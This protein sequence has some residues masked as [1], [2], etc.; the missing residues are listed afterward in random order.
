MAFLRKSI[1]LL[2]GALAAVGCEPNPT[3]GA[4]V[5]TIEG[6]PAGV[7]VAARVTGPD[8]FATT[9]PATGTIEGLIPGE[10]RV[11]VQS[12]T[13]GGD[14]Y[15]SSV[16]Q[17]MLN[18]AAG[19][20][21]SSTIPYALTSGSM[22]FTIGG[23][24]TGASANVI[25][26]RS[27]GFARLVPASGVQRG[28]GAGSYTIHADTTV[29]AEGDKFGPSAPQQTVTIAAS[30]TPVPVSVAFSQTTGTIALSI[31]GLPSTVPF[32]PVTV[33][34]PQG[35]FRSTKVSTSFHGLAPGTYTISAANAAGDC[36][37]MYVANAAQQ[38][39]EV[40]AVG[41]TMGSVSY[42]NGAANP[43]DLNL[44]IVSSQVIQV[45]Q[46]SAGNV[47]IVANRPALLRIYGIANQCNEVVPG[48]RVTFS[49]GTVVNVPAPEASVRTLLSEGTL[50]ATWNVDIP[51]TEV[52]AGLSFNAV[53]D[54]TNAFAEA[55]ES[56][57]RY[58]ASG[59][60]AVNVVALAPVKLVM[61]PVSQTTHGTGAISQANID[62]FL[63]F[64]RRVHPVATYDVVLGPTFSTQ[65]NLSSG[66]DVNGWA[67]I[68]NQLDAARVADAGANGVNRFHHG[69]VA[70]PFTGLVIAG[71]AYV[72]GWSGLTWDRLPSASEI[73]AHEFGHNYNQLHAPCPLSIEPGGPNSPDP[74]YPYYRAQIGKFGY[75]QATQTLRSPTAYTDVMGYCG[76]QWISDYMYKR[77]LA[78]L[79]A[80]QS[81]A[82]AVAAKTTERVLLVWGRIINGA[83]VLEPAFEIDGRAQLPGPGPHR[84]AALTPDGSE[85]FNIS[86]AGNDIADLPGDNESFAFTVPVSALGGQQVESLLLT[87]RGR[88]VRN[89]ISVEIAAG[90]TSDP[91]LRMDR[92]GARE[93]RLRWNAARYPVVMVRDPASGQVLSFA[94]GGDATLVI[95]SNELELHYSN[96]VRS[97]R[98]RQAIP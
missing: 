44:R 69:I 24:P 2:I 87:A 18:V 62:Q 17:Q 7:P 60:K 94:R 66:N 65:T 97:V 43:A 46:D 9:V 75:D 33:S 95:D 52:Q 20:T 29:T 35:Y 49:N 36:P 15:T 88:T 28:L 51:G 27:D 31:S 41:T 14:L 40:S 67:S 56:D 77:M 80:R 39:I 96:R 26:R 90:P 47:P 55:N 25:V 21:E 45:T 8:N 78:N 61:V 72:G 82:A 37:T 98:V 22:D 12:V 93:A 59:D 1:P 42:A 48:V 6:L 50:L 34:G 58:P 81:A 68:L 19:A 83:P 23:L 84:L 38:T 4:I 79:L 11:R 70:V 57:N 53:I 54:P 74:T 64:S 71:I 13:V 86:F 63:A 3:T 76:S 30:Q 73:V 92:V 16:T 91:Q 5:L 89:R 10:Y 32:D 85:A